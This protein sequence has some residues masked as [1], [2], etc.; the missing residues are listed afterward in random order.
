[1]NGLVERLNEVGGF[2]SA[3]GFTFDSATPDRVTGHL[4]VDDRHLQPFGIVHGGVWCALVED[5]A[6]T[7]ALL[8]AGGDKNVVGVSNTTD[9]IRPVGAG[10]VDVE[11]T[12][13]HVGRTQHLWQV[14]LTNADGKLVARGQVRLQVLGPMPEGAPNWKE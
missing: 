10:R 12:P 1:M 6:S 13:I 7:G 9:F 5:F 14:R 8:A 4:E 2:Q 11:A 3:V